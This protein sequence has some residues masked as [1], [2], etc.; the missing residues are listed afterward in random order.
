MNGL[1][2]G[3][4]IKIADD[5]QKDNS[6]PIKDVETPSS[7]SESNTEEANIKSA[8][9]LLDGNNM[10]PELAQQILKILYQSNNGC[11]Y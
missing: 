10:T 3:V 4:A 9:D 6:Q 5:S 11:I 7:Q 8:L 1:Q 2:N